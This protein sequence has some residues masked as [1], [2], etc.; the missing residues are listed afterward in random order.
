MKYWATIIIFCHLCFPQS[1]FLHREQFTRV[2]QYYIEEQH[3][4]LNLLGVVVYSDKNN[5]VLRLDIQ[6]TNV[7]S[8][9]VPGIFSSLG[10]ISLYSEETIDELICIFHPDNI[11]TIPLIYSAKTSCTTAC[12]LENTMTLSDWRG[13]C[14]ISR[15][16]VSEN[17]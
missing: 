5:V 13:T 16:N 17:R 2:T 8:I 15:L 11:E 12:F 14:L 7:S 4:S 9:D 1:G 3:P 10:K 6:E